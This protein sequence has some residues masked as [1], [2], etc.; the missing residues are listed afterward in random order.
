M[1][2]ERWARW[3]LRLVK[4]VCWPPL[5]DNSW[6]RYR[7]LGSA[8]SS[9]G[10]TLKSLLSGGR[11]RWRQ[12]LRRS[13]KLE[14]VESWEG[15]N[16]GICHDIAWHDL[17]F[18]NLHKRLRE[19]KRGIN[20][21][22]NHLVSYGVEYC[23]IHLQVRRGTGRI[24]KYYRTNLLPLATL[25]SSYIT[26]NISTLT[27]ISS[28]HYTK[29]QSPKAQ[30]Q[31]HTHPSIKIHELPKLQLSVQTRRK[32]TRKSKVHSSTPTKRSL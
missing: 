7:L 12:N 9:G 5:Y 29:T 19:D 22:L 20:D 23:R 27:R 13:T 24:R 1:F 11:V 31:L 25:P 26:T 15:E 14:E 30:H 4:R 17:I 32:Q 6:H 16:V 2:S 21:S 10:G 8:S 3:S 18:H 28:S